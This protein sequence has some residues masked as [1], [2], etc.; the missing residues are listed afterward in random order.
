MSPLHIPNETEVEDKLNISPGLNQQVIMVFGF[1]CLIIV[2]NGNFYSSEVPWR[3][4]IKKRII[5]TIL[6]LHANTSGKS[7][8]TQKIFSEVRSFWESERLK[9]A[10]FSASIRSQMLSVALCVNVDPFDFFR[11]IGGSKGWR[12]E[13]NGFLAAT[14]L[15]RQWKNTLRNDVGSIDDKDNE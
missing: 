11:T 6:A 15:S 13:S 10:F 3:T 2:R 4:Y 14:T 1:F 7:I 12:T 5:E 9:F 8:V